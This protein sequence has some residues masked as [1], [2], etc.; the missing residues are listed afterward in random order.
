MLA[1]VL[2]VACGTV[3]APDGNIA[4]AV[5]VLTEARWDALVNALASPV[6]ASGDPLE[7]T[8]SGSVAKPAVA[9]AIATVVTSSTVNGVTTSPCCGQAPTAASCVAALFC[10][11]P[12]SPPLV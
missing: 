6:L 1:S 9:N 8:C 5:P 10:P 12:E 2:I 11:K 7:E 3:A 4:G